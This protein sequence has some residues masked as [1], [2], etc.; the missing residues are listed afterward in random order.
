MPGA[1][2]GTLFSGDH[3]NALCRAIAR[4]RLRDGRTD[5]TPP[6]D[7]EQALTEW[8]DRKKLTAYEEQVIATHEAG[9]A[10]CA[11]LC[12][13]A[14]AIK[15]I[16]L[17][18]DLMGGAS[19]VRHQD[20]TNGEVWTRNQMMARSASPSAAGRR[21]SCFSATCR[22]AARRT[23]SRRRRSPGTWS[24]CTAWAAMR[25][26]RR[27]FAAMD[28]E[29]KWTRSH[30]SP[31]ALE[32]ADR[33]IREILEEGR[34]QAATILRENRALVESLRDMLIEKRVIEAKTLQTMTESKH[35]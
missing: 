33:R 24:R 1:A 28:P 14:E 27:S 11:L 29:G 9:H 12:P 17:N 34:K 4:M 10:V 23:C 8:V 30:L 20:P 18:D 25:S 31:A 22:G 21:S 32:A 6:E 35:G 2:A 5:E 3:L 16:A 15:R 19:Y 7:V 13:H 26:A